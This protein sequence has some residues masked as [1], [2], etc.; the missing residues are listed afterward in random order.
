[1]HYRIRK[2]KKAK[3]IRHQLSWSVFHLLQA[4]V[5]SLRKMSQAQLCWS[6][7]LLGP[8]HG[9]GATPSPPATSSGTTSTSPTSK[10]WNQPQ[11]WIFLLDPMALDLGPVVFAHPGQGELLKPLQSWNILI[12]AAPLAGVKLFRAESGSPQQGPPSEVVIED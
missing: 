10:A 9:K 5:L 1:M 6:Q 8:Q 4:A 11:K 12:N 2:I 7:L 3:T